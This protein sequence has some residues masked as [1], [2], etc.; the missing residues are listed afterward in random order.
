[1]KN[2]QTFAEFINESTINESIAISPVSVIN[3]IKNNV[4][5]FEVKI[6][7]MVNYNGL[8]ISLDTNYFDFQDAIDMNSRLEFQDIMKDLGVDIVNVNMKS[9]GRSIKGAFG[10]HSKNLD[11]LIGITQSCIIPAD[12][13]MGEEI[14]KALKKYEGKSIVR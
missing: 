13:K 5:D 14:L 4:S 9:G 11:G 7:S 12:K 6:T 3:F 1:M 2:L 8:V 10:F